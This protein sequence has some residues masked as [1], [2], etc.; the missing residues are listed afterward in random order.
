MIRPLLLAALLVPIAACNQS[1]K[2]TS[3]TINGD[4]GTM[5]GGVDGNSGEVKIDVPGFKASVTM[6]KIKIDAGDFDLNGVKLYPGSS[7]E[8][9]NVQGDTDQK[10]GVRVH[11]TSPAT[12]DTVRGWFAERLGKVGYTIRTDGANLV[13]T[14]DENKP[15]RLDLTPDGSDKAKGTILIGG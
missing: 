12:P 7:I 14:T 11:F 4:N 9:I 3:V 6:P 5:I 1:E 8:G 2:G 15:F 10:G 13:G